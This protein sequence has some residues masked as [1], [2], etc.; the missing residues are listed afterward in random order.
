MFA[1]DPRQGNHEL[2]VKEHFDLRRV[3]GSCER[4]LSENRLALASIL[5]EGPSW[6]APISVQNDG[7]ILIDLEATIPDQSVFFSDAVLS[8]LAELGIFAKEQGQIEYIVPIEDDRAVYFKTVRK[9]EYQHYL[10]TKRRFNCHV[11]TAASA[12]D[13]LKWDT[14]LQYDFEQQ[15]VAEAP[16]N[17]CGFNV[18]AEYFQW[19]AENGRLV[20]ARISDEAGDTLG[21]CY[22]VP[23]DFQLFVVTY[24]RRIGE[25]YAKHGLGKALIFA[26]IDHIYDHGLLTPLNLGNI[27]YDYKE[28]WR[29]IPGAVRPQLEFADRVAQ[30]AFFDRFHGRLGLDA[31]W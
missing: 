19:L 2:Y 31:P 12:D 8:G 13:V 7:R 14:E 15:W 24:K 26:L 1:G 30:E 4:R 21:L 29:P 27:L 5:V 10:N 11:L 18:E 20:L 23:G 9:N 28:I 3:C 6:V 16:S 22:C 17:A 25:A